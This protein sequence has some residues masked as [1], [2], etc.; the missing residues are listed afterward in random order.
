MQKPLPSDMQVIAHRRAPLGEGSVWLVRTA[1]PLEFGPSVTVTDEREVPREVFRGM[2]RGILDEG[3][4][5][6]A[7]LDEVC[8]Y[9]EWSSGEMNCRLWQ[10]RDEESWLNFLELLPTSDTPANSSGS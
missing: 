10:A 6:T 4:N 8:Q 3:T 9:Y 2:L 1:E 7:S 5:F